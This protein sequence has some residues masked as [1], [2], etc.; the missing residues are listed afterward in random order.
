MQRQRMQ[1]TTKSLAVR[2]Q[3]M[4]MV[5]KIHHAIAIPTLKPHLSKHFRVGFA[6]WH[7]L[8]FY[9]AHSLFQFILSL[10]SLIEMFL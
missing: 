8:R 7:V 5:N 1:F 9:F 2:P 10:R 4:K 3:K 6:G